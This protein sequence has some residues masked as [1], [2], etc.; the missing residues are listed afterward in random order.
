[1]QSAVATVAL[2]FLACS[3]SGP[4][5]PGCGYETLDYLAAADAYERPLSPILAAPRAP[6][7]EPLLG[8]AAI[9]ATDPAEYEAETQRLE[10]AAAETLGR[11][12][13]AAWKALVDCVP[14]DDA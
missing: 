14:G 9:L 6:D 5:R 7:G 12:L 1:M 8:P 2:V 10:A 3:P 13:D 4:E 11:N